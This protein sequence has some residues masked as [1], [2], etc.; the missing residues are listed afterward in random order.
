M[1]NKFDGFVVF[2]NYYFLI[3]CF[4]F[5][6]QYMIYI[7]FINIEGKEIVLTDEASCIHNTG[8][9]NDGL[10]PDD[11]KPLPEPKLTYYQRDTVALFLV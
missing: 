11:I 2:E 6:M 4:S 9:G 7:L 8:S 1:V 5:W 10:L 3:L